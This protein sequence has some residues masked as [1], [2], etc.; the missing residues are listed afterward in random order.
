MSR[1]L[2]FGVFSLIVLASVACAHHAATPQKQPWVVG[3]GLRN[4]RRSGATWGGSDPELDWRA[5]AERCGSAVLDT[6]PRLMIAVEGPQYSTDF[7]AFAR[8]P[9]TL[10]VPD[11][12]VCSPHAYASSAHTFASYEEMKQAYDARAGFLLQNKPEVPLRVGEFVTCQTLDCGANSRW[13][14]L[15][16]RVPEREKSQLGLLAVARS[17]RSP[18]ATAGLTTHVRLTEAVPGVLAL[19]DAG[20]WR[21]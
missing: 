13:F 1:L 6:N 10:K 3:A 20:V 8:L 18:Q 12:L 15:V 4:E 14:V 19:D 7:V 17:E 11:R 9:L 5:A 16:G 21:I 2:H